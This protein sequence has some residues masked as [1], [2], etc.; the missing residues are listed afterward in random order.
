MFPE[1]LINPPLLFT[2]N[3]SPVDTAPTIDTDWAVFQKRFAGDERVS[4]IVPGRQFG[5]PRL[6]LH[7]SYDEEHLAG[8]PV[9]HRLYIIV[10]AEVARES[11]PL[12]GQISVPS[13]KE[14]IAQKIRVVQGELTISVLTGVRKNGSG[15]SIAS[16]VSKATLSGIS[17]GEIGSKITEFVPRGDT[18]ENGDLLDGVISVLVDL[19]LEAGADLGLDV[20]ERKKLSAEIR[21]AVGK[22]YINI[23]KLSGGGKKK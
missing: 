20:P 13:R 7:R 12:P 11:L 3:P 18:T 16:E 17:L 2:L 1:D 23:G 14:F 5:K 21:F 19:E 22:Q 4:G 15:G 8:Y 9:S 10:N 6:W